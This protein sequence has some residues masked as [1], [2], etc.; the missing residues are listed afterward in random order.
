VLA[1]EEEVDNNSDQEDE[2]RADNWELHYFLYI[3]Y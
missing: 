2:D 3:V 1:E